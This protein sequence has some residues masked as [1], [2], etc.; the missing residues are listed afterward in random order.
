MTCLRYFTVFMITR[1]VDPLLCLTVS[2]TL[3]EKPLP[4]TPARR[5]IAELID[6]AGGIPEVAASTS[7]A[8]SPTREV[9]G[10]ESTDDEEDN[11]VLTGLSEVNL[12]EGLTAG[13]HKSSTLLYTHRA[14]A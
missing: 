7:T 3:R 10:K 1:I 2:I 12:L 6:A 4:F 13:R 9:N 14:R 5:M 8:V 11:L